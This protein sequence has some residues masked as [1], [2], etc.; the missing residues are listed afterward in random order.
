MPK[1]TDFRS[2]IDEGIDI[3]PIAIEDI[4]GRPQTVL[5]RA[6]MAALVRGNRILI[7][8]AGGTIGSELARQ[9]AEFGPDR[10]CLLDSSEYQLYQIDLEISEHHPELTRRSV[11]AD[12]RESTRIHAIIAQEMPGLV[13]H[14]PIVEAHPEEGILTNAIGT[15]I[16]A[17]ACRTNNV[18]T[19][20][21]ISTDKAVNPTSLMGSTKRIA[22]SYCQALDLIDRGPDRTRFVTVRFGNVLGSTGS[23]VPLFQRQLAAGRSLDR[24][25]SGDDALLHDRSRGRGAGPRGVRTRFAGQGKRGQDLC[26]RYG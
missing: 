11:L 24:D 5:D 12:V 21:L 26:S 19:M 25:P 14:A 20:V 13:F 4:L 7:T 10:L 22:E 9:I 17:D 18:G 6:S 15:Q 23:V 8:G 2:G 3:K 16:V 1:L